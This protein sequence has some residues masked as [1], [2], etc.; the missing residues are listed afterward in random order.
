[1]AVSRHLLSWNRPFSRRAPGGYIL[2]SLPGTPGRAP[3]G[4]A[5]ERRGTAVADRPGR[6]G[7]ASRAPWE[8]HPAIAFGAT[9]ASNPS[10]ERTLE[11]N[12][13]QAS[14]LILPHRAFDGDIRQSYFFSC[15]S[16][17]RLGNRNGLVPSTSGPCHVQNLRSAATQRPRCSRFDDPG[18]RDQQ[19]R[20]T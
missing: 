15:C 8:S 16:P 1:M 7:N 17:T 4:L 10:S 13:R 6:P 5:G 9:S 20:V 14:S 12:V 11:L 18:R 3:K 19:T 2:Y